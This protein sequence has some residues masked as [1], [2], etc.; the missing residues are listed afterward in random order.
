MTTARSTS[1]RTVFYSIRTLEPLFGHNPAAI[2]LWIQLD[3]REP[4]RPTLSLLTELDR[5][6]QRFSRTLEIELEM[7]SFVPDAHRYRKGP[8]EVCIATA[9]FLN[10]DILLMGKDYKQIVDLLKE[11][12]ITLLLYRD[13]Q[14]L[15]EFIE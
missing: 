3:S 8:T 6:I 4:K 9:E 11:T 1:T 7:Y 14:L 2:I 12:M 10:H 15:P 5:E 13:M